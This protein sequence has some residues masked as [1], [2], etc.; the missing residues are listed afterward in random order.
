MVLAVTKIDCLQRCCGTDSAG[1]GADDHRAIELNHVQF[2]LGF[3][4]TTLH[5]QPY[6]RAGLTKRMC[7]ILSASC[8]RPNN[9]SAPRP[10]WVR[11]LVAAD[12][13]CALARLV[14]H[15]RNSNFLLCLTWGSLSNSRCLPGLCPLTIDAGGQPALSTDYYAC[16]V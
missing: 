1:N 12:Y 14:R 10:N 16:I 2:S 5:G 4:A 3:S 15:Y 7:S 8:R 6:S 9:P 13:F 11:F